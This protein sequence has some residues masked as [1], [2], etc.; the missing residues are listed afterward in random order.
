MMRLGFHYILEM[1]LQIL[2][3]KDD[4]NISLSLY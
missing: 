3:T 2:F 4:L 1:E